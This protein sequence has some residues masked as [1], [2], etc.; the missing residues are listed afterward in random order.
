MLLLFSV[1][2]YFVEY[3]NILF[4]N[5]ETGSIVDWWLRRWIFTTGFQ[6]VNA[7]SSWSQPL[8][9][10]RC[11]DMLSATWL[12]PAEEYWRH[13]TV[14]HF[15]SVGRWPTWAAEPSVQL[16]LESGTIVDGPQTSGQLFQT[17]VGDIFIRSLGQKRSVNPTLTS[18]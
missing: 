13:L 16:D 6:C 3:F 1:C 18:F 15:S 4:G 10:G 17:V 8:S 12:T 11:L 14:V 7:S 5:V 2:A 9:A